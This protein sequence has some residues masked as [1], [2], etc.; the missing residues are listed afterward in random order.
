[1]GS[2]FTG[3]HLSA[4]SV[5]VLNHSQENELTSNIISPRAI[6]NTLIFGYKDN[7]LDLLIFM[8]IAVLPTYMYVWVVR[9]PGTGVTDGCKLS[10]ECWEL[11]LD[12]LKKHT[13]LLIA[14]LSLQP[15]H[16]L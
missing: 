9:S 15:V 3:N 1:V 7:Y 8:C 12:P 2:R 5:L 11:N 16:F 4:D 13:V 6:H 14:E 10:C